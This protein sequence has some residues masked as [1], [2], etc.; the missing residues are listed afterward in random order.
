M[1]VTII[2]TSGTREQH[3]IPRHSAIREIRKL[4]GAEC[5]DTVNLR[6]GDVL[7]VDDTGMVDGRPVNPEATKL[8][9]GVCRAGTVHC[10]HGDVAV[11]RDADFE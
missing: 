1:N 2:R 8:Y 3:D 11:A 10:I 9:H 7:L 4:I 6:N 5:L